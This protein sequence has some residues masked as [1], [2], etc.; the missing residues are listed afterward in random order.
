M[1]TTSFRLS[2][3][4]TLIAASLMGGCGS[5][6]K[7][8][9]PVT[10][11]LK[12][13]VA[14]PDWRDQVVYFLL[15]DRFN[16]GDPTNND[17][18]AE[19]YDPSKLE[20]YSGGD[21][22]GVTDKLDYINGLGATSI[23]LSAPVANQWKRDIEGG[24]TG[25][26]GYWASDFTQVD[27][28]LGD[29]K[30]YQ[31]LSDGLHSR[32]MYLIQDI[33]TN[34]MGDF[35]GYD[36]S[37]M[38]SKDPCAGYVSHAEQSHPMSAPVMAPFN[39]NDPCKDPTADSFHW[40][41]NL[42]NYKD[43]LEEKS[44]QLSDLDDINTSS[45][46]VRTALK[47][48]Y[49]DWIR[50]VG[51]DAF[52]MDTIKYVEHDFLNDFIHSADGVDATAKA[53]GREHFYT[54]G[55]VW[56][57]DF[58]EMNDG[59]EKVL[60]TYQ[61]ST[62]K[63]EADALLNFPLQRTLLNVFASGSATGDLAYRLEVANNGGI[64]RDPQLTPNFLDSHDAD[65]YL[66]IGNKESFKQ[67]LMALMTIP[68]V[69]VIYYGS[70]QGFTERRAA[71]F[72]SG[73]GSGGI[74]HF[75]TESEFYKYISEVAHM[76][77]S[78]P[79][80]TRGDIQ[81]LA[82]NANS[83]G[84]LVYA[85]HYEGQTALVVFNTAAT[86]TLINQV[87]TGLPEGTELQVLAATGVELEMV[88]VGESGLLTMT[89]P[90]QSGVTL[91]ASS[92]IAGD[93]T[94]LG[95]A[96]T[97]APASDSELTTGLMLHGT[98]ND[99]GAKTLKLVVDDN[100]S[101]ARDVTLASDGS[102]KAVL[103]ISAFPSG[104]SSHHFALYSPERGKASVNMPFNV[105]IAAEVL[106]VEVTDAVGDEAYL[107]PTDS[108]FD[109]QMDMTLLSA[110]ASG[111]Q[112]KLIYTMSNLTTTWNPSNGFD[113]VLFNTFIQLP[114]KSGGATVL[115]NLNASAPADFSWNYLVRSEGW[116]NKLYSAEGA[117]ASNPGTVQNA[118]FSIT[119]DAANKTV[120][121]SINGSSLDIL[122][123]QQ[124]KVYVTTWDW[125]GANGTMRPLQTA[126]GDWNFGGG[127]GSVE[128]LIMDQSE[129]LQLP[130]GGAK[131]SDIA[132][133]EAYPYPQAIDGDKNPL[134]D[135]QQDFLQGTASRDGNDLVVTLK[136][137]K[138]TDGWAPSNGFDRVRL[139]L[140]FGLANGTTGN[141]VLPFSQGSV[142]AGM[143]W[144]MLSVVD[145]WNNTLYQGT[146]TA[147]SFGSEVA[148]VPV[149]TTDVAAGTITLRY[150]ASLLGG[151]AAL[152]GGQLYIT[153]WDYNGAT[154][155]YRPLDPTG[156]EW[157]Y[158]GPSTAPY[159][160]DDMFIALPS[161]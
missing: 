113:H 42:N 27:K 39:N 141:T 145:G 125:N 28:H 64:L 119:A 101:A 139:S 85:R 103:D 88:A 52:R 92:N 78:H 81:V 140:Y 8:T 4:A 152:S 80:L 129:V 102:W 112:L 137:R 41:P 149:V 63:P 158:Q 146:A 45:P 131:V 19:E 135:G 56:Q 104:K 114:G 120:V 106:H 147:S 83:A 54:F 110:D 93:L 23:W 109:K 115:P 157:S 69:P 154:N 97:N 159:V 1:P 29:L 49:G 22:K 107:Y 148:G 134:F 50:N 161:F 95:V 43:P 5:D 66:S 123:W 122:D 13:H 74:D 40:T 75:D 87:D 9:T 21:I 67:A 130:A 32:G 44:Y 143:S 86:S 59:D 111:S 38:D 2:L 155:A 36:A 47:Q 99:S 153:S 142:P 35:F 128:P 55:E 14:S 124:A 76:R 10:P 68:G 15:A 73:Y 108:S 127:D 24:L 34:H 77:T 37:K 151:F 105:D 98:L 20:Y 18:G 11:E 89:L 51:V 46:A 7:Q 3:L 71:M 82:S 118:K 31:Q 156:G 53:T 33:V 116:S 94:P 132:A 121:L 126:A 16:D 96:I 61:G 91:L 138:V 57:T 62:D 150:P 48:A 84:G 26:H 65:R 72:A 79:V 30:T 136:M 144:D 100:L 25:Y 12:L 117:S 60:A 70:E 160:Q 90:A 58:G 6:K 17:Q 133:D